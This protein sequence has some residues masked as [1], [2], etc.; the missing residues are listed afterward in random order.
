MPAQLVNF[1]KVI[2]RL[3][4]PSIPRH[5]LAC[6]LCHSL[7]MVFPNPQLNSETLHTNELIFL[8]FSSS[9]SVWGPCASPACK[10]QHVTTACFLWT[11]TFSRGAWPSLAG[12]LVSFQSDDMLER[13]RRSQGQQPNGAIKLQTRLDEDVVRV[14]FYKKKHRQMLLTRYQQPSCWLNQHTAYLN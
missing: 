2:D 7:H 8:F 3:I 9:F 1:S 13:H 6:A 12:K 5:L 10:C 11:W 14:F 4:E